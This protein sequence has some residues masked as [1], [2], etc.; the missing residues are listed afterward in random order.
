MDFGTFQTRF[1]FFFLLTNAALNLP[2]FMVQ[3]HHKANGTVVTGEACAS[4]ISN[5]DRRKK[6]F[7]SVLCLL[8]GRHFTNSISLVLI[9]IFKKDAFSA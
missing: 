6:V 9:L 1:P 8:L 3:D 5:Y 7:K 4:G 2:L